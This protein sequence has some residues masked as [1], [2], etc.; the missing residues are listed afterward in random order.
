MSIVRFLVLCDIYKVVLFYIVLIIDE[1][2]VLI[3][4]VL[5]AIRIIEILLFRFVIL[6]AIRFVFLV[7]TV[8]LVVS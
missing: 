2:L 7:D 4:H 6:F 3:F 8:R 1:C 5:K